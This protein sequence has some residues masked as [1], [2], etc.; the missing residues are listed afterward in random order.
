MD[1]PLPLQVE[2]EP[3]SRDILCSFPSV[4][5]ILRV[6]LDEGNKNLGLGFLKTG[7]WVNIVNIICEV[8]SGLWRGVLMSFTKFRIA[9]QKYISLCLRLLSIPFF[10]HWHV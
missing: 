1:N 7:D 9:P 4:G 3:L 10:Y 8:H 6:V 5:S 2:A